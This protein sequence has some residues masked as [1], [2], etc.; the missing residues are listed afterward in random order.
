MLVDS[1]PRISLVDCSS[2]IGK[3]RAS[4]KSFRGAYTQAVLTVFGNELK[5]SPQVLYG[6]R[7]LEI[8]G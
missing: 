8:F 6:K 3:L 4:G 7:L 1:Q 5:P 2:L